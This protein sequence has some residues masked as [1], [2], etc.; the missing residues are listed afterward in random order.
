MSV[1]SRQIDAHFSYAIS[2]L[3][4]FNF[5]CVAINLHIL[6][7]ASKC[8]TQS[9]HH[10]TKRMMKEMTLD[11]KGTIN[12][13]GCDLISKEKPKCNKEREKKGTFRANNKLTLISLNK[14][15]QRQRKIFNRINER[16]GEN[17]NK[18]KFFFVWFMLTHTI[19]NRICVFVCSRYAIDVPVQ[20]KCKKKIHCD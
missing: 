4:V 2:H 14:H 13:A 6:I 12:D 15:K 7:D 9:A 5:E 16:N 19:H 18:H 17:V 1:R 10:F 8:W 20:Y 11:F 3:L